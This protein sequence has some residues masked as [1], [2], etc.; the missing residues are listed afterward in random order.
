MKD[1]EFEN[2]Q[3]K[4]RLCFSI[5]RNNKSR[6]NIDNDVIDKVRTLT[7]IQLDTQ[8]NCSNF[9]CRKCQNN[10]LMFSKFREEMIEKHQKF[11]DFIKTDDLTLFEY[12]K[13][14]PLFSNN[15][16]IKFEN[17]GINEEAILKILED[18]DNEAESEISSQL[19][20][21]RSGKR[22]NPLEDKQNRLQPTTKCLN[23][24]EN[25]SEELLNE[26]RSSK[27]HSIVCDICGKSFKMKNIKRH[28]RMFHKNLK[29]H[30]C[31]KCG[32]TFDSKIK[33]RRHV[34]THILKE[35]RI[36]DFQ[37]DIC[38]R[39]FLCKYSLDSHK[40]RHTASPESCSFCGKNYPNRIARR[41]HELNI[42]VH[43][44]HP[45]KICGKKCTTH[46]LKNHIKCC[47]NKEGQKE[48]MCELCGKSFRF[49]KI[50]NYHL[51]LHEDKTVSCDFHN[52][53]KQFRNSLYL[54]IH[55][56]RHEARKK[57]SCTFPDCNRSY[58]VSSNLKKHIFIFH[59]KIREKCPVG[60]GCKFSVGRIDYMRNHLKKHSEL[61]P[62]ELR[63]FIDGLKSKMNL[64]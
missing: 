20:V 48:F 31:D 15:N 34:V 64:V 42:H 1:I 24:N 26:T 36:R 30:Q 25:V 3:N 45:C 9:I 62:I 12:I 54:K 60:N 51:K 52:C 29:P 56:K 6:V 18:I 40:M 38:E 14:E 59:K 35:C 11:E 47:H 61:N 23:P 55:Q 28:K 4:C 17:S 33:A 5:P 63:N 44:A 19:S 10:I 46:S 7:E 27:S 43:A 8:E 2:H 37:C 53:N 13:V 57:F 32:N 49:K 16:A 22:N 41:T 21:T 39:K 50:L 58:Y